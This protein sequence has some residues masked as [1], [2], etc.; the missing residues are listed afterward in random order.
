MHFDICLRL[1]FKKMLSDNR[2]TLLQQLQ[3]I[4]TSSH[5]EG[6]MSPQSQKSVSETEDSSRRVMAGID[7]F[8]LDCQISWPLS[9]VLSRRSIFKYQLL[10]RHIFSINH[11]TLQ[12]RHPT[13]QKAFLIFEKRER[14][15]ERFLFFFFLGGGGS[16]CPKPGKGSKVQGF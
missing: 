6:P 15:R 5:E 4:F 12:V 16:R 7:T 8:V 2:E 9:L 13:K 11:L 3:R 14:E 1:S 10:F